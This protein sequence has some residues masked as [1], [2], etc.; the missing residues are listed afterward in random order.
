M[1]FLTETRQAQLACAVALLPVLLLAKAPRLAAVL[2]LA[3]TGPL[4]AWRIGLF[5][6]ARLCVA[7][8]AMGGVCVLLGAAGAAL[9]LLLDDAVAAH[10]CLG[11]GLCIGA[12]QLLRQQYLAVH[13]FRAMALP[14]CA[15]IIVLLIALVAMGITPLYPLS[16]RRFFQ[17]ACVPFLLLFSETATHAPVA[18][19]PKEEPPPPPPKTTPAVLPL[20]SPFY[21]HKTNLFKQQLL[22]HQ[23]HLQQQRQLRFIMN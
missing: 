5:M 14:M 12:A 20:C 16:A 10:L 15:G 17:S 1:F 21:P 8:R 3:L 7:G 18:T 22:Q 4:T 6:W 11:G 2:H 13:R 9:L 23:L 19:A